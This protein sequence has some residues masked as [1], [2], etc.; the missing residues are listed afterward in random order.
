[1]QVRRLTRDALLTAIALT[2]FM[3]EAQ[4][5][6][7]I[8][9]P[10]I[11]LGLA[12]IITLYALFMLGPWDAL[13]ILLARIVLG[14][15]FAGNMMILLYSLAGGLLCWLLCCVLRRMMTDRQIWLCSIFGAIAHN[16]G[17]MAVAIAV[18]RTLG[19]LAYLPALM[20]SGRL[21][22]AFTGW[23]AQFLIG[24]MKLM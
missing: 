12:N 24:R 21:A 16:L 15:L 6:A 20:I 8:P 2:I 11:K 18:T 13:G 5:P 17:Q 7:P 22:G 10:G 19:L 14:S 9:I 3:I 1:M 4:I 23:S